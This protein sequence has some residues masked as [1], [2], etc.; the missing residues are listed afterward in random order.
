MSLSSKLELM[1]SAVQSAV[2]LIAPILI[3]TTEKWATEQ[4]Y[5]H[6]EITSCK[7]PSLAKIDFQF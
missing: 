5:I 2:Q 6:I 3:L 4:S 1:Q 7:V